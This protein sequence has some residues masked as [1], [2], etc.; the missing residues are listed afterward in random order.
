MDQ[1]IISTF[2]ILDGL[3]YYTD[4]LWFSN[5]NRKKL[6]T[7]YIEAE[8]IWSYRAGLSSTAKRDIVFP[9]GKVFE[10]SQH[11]RPKK[12]LLK[13]KMRELQEECL[14]EIQKMTTSG[15]TN[16]DC[17]LGALYIMSS[18]VMVSK[19]AY[20]A[21]SHLWNPSPLCPYHP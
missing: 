2:Q 14:K 9:S 18:L 7:F 20:T 17:I 3:N 1:N 5:L 16:A 4:T 19:G 12:K 15:K 13:M 11:R 8:D 6:L 21:Y 10:L